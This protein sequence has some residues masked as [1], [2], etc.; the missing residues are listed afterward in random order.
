M[1]A[2]ICA[3]AL[4]TALSAFNYIVQAQGYIVPHGVTYLGFTIA[5]GYETHVIQNP[6]NGDYT[7]FLLRPQDGTA[8]RFS[9]F[10][11]ESVRAF[12]ISAGDPVSS[13]PIF[14]NSYP[15]LTYPNSYV[16]DDG[17]PFYLGLYTGYGPFDSQGH[18]TGIYKDPVFAWGQ[19][20]NSGGAIEMLDSALEYGGGGI[21]A[22]TENIIPS[23]PEPGALGL[24]GAAAFLFGLRRSC[25][26]RSG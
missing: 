12:L 15:E 13:P 5:G 3:L 7:G 24:L 4:T 9:P 2:R 16:F 21:Y 10:T 11:D 6:T 14:A 23:V 18:Y 17:V 8:F 19:F 26:R 22:G 20:V 1:N 25:K